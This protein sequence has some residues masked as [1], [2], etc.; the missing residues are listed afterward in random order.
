MIP[1]LFKIIWGWLR[2]NWINGI[3]RIYRGGIGVNRRGLGI[4][5]LM[6]IWDLSRPRGSIASD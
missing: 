6:V 5:R 2:V 4:N 1:R 3:N